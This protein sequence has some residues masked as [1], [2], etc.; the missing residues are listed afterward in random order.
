MKVIN[1]HEININFNELFGEKW[2]K[3][4]SDELFSETSLELMMELEN[5]YNSKIIFPNKNDIFNA[6]KYCDP[7]NLKV[8]IIGEEPYN[9]GSSNGIAFGNKEKVLEI[10]P[11]LKKIQKKIEEDFYNGV[12]LGF[13]ITLKEWA[14]QGVLLLNYAMTVEDGKPKSH[15]ALWKDFI[16]DLVISLDFYYNDIIFCLWGRTARELIPYI[17]TQYNTLYTYTSPSVAAQLEVSW[18]CEHFKLINEKLIKKYGS[19]GE[20]VW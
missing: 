10:S 14:K 12:N 3:I 18:E 2:V 15:R 6:F 1:N 11:E 20:I 13:D 19:K 8:I 5:E 4:L 9:D 7:N 17:S 16:S